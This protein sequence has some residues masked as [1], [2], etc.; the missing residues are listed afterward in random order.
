MFVSLILLDILL[1][2]PCKTSA[3]IPIVLPQNVGRCKKKAP[4]MVSAGRRDK[5]EKS[6]NDMQACHSGSIIETSM[7]FYR[8]K[9]RMDSGFLQ[10]TKQATRMA[11]TCRR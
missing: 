4:T 8:I 11:S 10:T 5:A 9:S 6:L 1:R 7:D 3:I 2:C